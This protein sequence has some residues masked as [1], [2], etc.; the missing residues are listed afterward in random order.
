MGEYC[1]DDIPNI[2]NRHNIDCIILPSQ[3]P[4]TFSFVFHELFHPSLTYFVSNL[5]IFTNEHD[6][7]RNEN[8]FKVNRYWDINSWEQTLSKHYFKL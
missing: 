8:I 3:D 4:E 2:L 7:P 6:I 1:L 5:G